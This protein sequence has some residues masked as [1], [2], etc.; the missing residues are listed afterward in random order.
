MRLGSSPRPEE[1]GD[2]TF[3]EKFGSGSY[4]FSGSESSIRA[5][6]L[7]CPTWPQ[8]LLVRIS[9]RDFLSGRP[10]SCLSPAPRAGE[11]VQPADPVPVSA[12]AGEVTS[13]RRSKRFP[14]RREL[15]N[16]R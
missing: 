7:G 5:W 2:F 10:Q 4:R 3:L 12:A 11:G 16:A 6:T 8:P 1:A 15:R 13:F 14:I 9:G